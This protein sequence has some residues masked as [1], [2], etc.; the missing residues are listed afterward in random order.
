[1]GYRLTLLW[2]RL[3]PNDFCN[4]IPTHGHAYE[5]P[6]LAHWTSRISQFTP[7][8]L[9]CFVAPLEDGDLPLSKKDHESY[10][11]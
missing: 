3:P 11:P 8:S 10:E 5:D 2:T 4:C 6:I 9:P 7:N 1:M